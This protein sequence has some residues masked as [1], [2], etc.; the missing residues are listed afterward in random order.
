MI[1]VAAA[2]IRDGEKILVTRR[3][4]GGQFGG[5][6]EFPG[7]KVKAGEPPEAALARE[8]LEEL[9][10]VVSVG[11]FLGVFRYRAPG[12]GIELLAYRAVAE[13]GALRLTDHDGFLWAR[14]E[15]L[16]ASGFSPADIPLLQAL[17]KKAGR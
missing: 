14:P 16:D 15:D 9:G 12:G 11:K 5:L 6:W 8:I 2:V 10:L 3:K 7:G 13:S 4:P 17:K 1:K